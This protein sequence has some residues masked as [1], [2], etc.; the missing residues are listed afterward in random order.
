MEEANQTY[1]NGNLFKTMKRLIT[2]RVWLNNQ[3]V[4]DAEN[5]PGIFCGD[6]PVMQFSGMHDN[7]GEKVYDGDI[8]RVKE[9]INGGMKDW[10]SAVVVRFQNGSFCVY[11]PK[12]CEECRNGRGCISTLDECLCVGYVEVVGNIYENK[13]LLD[14]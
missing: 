9:Q 11:N 4:Y 2:F 5:I 1:F 7:N 8:L 12:C 6:D 10:K 14:G 3:M 13:N